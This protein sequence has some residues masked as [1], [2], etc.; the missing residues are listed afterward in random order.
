MRLWRRSRSKGK[1]R[2]TGP[3][4]EP[5]EPGVTVP[6]ENP[7]DREEASPWEAWLRRSPEVLRVQRWWE[8]YG[9]LRIELGEDAYRERLGE[10]LSR[11]APRD[12]AA[13][14]LGCNR[15]IDRSCREPET[16]SLDPV[17]P[18]PGEKPVERHGPVA[19]ACSAFVDCYSPFA[20]RA[21]FTADDRHRAVVVE[22]DRSGAMLWVDGIRVHAP[23]YLDETGYWVDDRFYV[24]EMVGPHDHPLQGI[25]AMGSMADVLSLVIH[26]VTTATTHVL[27][28]EPHE[29]WT[30]PVAWRVNGEWHVFPDREAAAARHPDRTF[31][32]LPPPRPAQP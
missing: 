22:G 12:F 29:S 19:G 3:Q 7:V 16:C 5:V 17:P 24:T 31:T 15:R 11:L 30:D 9:R 10:L 1:N 28:P 6:P 13:L 20:I 23:D 8:R 27:D 2:T 21:D 18:A 26:D 25:P 4:P 14:G 32:T